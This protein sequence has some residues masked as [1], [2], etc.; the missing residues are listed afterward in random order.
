MK[1]LDKKIRNIMI[2]IFVVFVLLI[3][4]TIVRHKEILEEFKKDHDKSVL[5]TS[6]KI[7][8]YGLNIKIISILGNNFIDKDYLEY[9]T[10]EK[11]ITNDEETGMFDYNLIGEAPE[12]K[13]KLS[14]IYG[15]GRIDT[16][17]LKE[18]EIEM[19]FYLN[20][21]IKNAYELINNDADIRYV[22]FNDFVSI[23]P[24]RSTEEYE[25]YEKYF[26]KSIIRQ[27]KINHYLSKIIPSE[28]INKSKDTIIGKTQYFIEHEKYNN[29][30]MLIE[31]IEKDKKL[32]GMISVMLNKNY[33]RTLTQGKNEV[34]ITTTS[35]EIFTSNNKKYMDTSLS[36]FEILNRKMG[37]KEKRYNEL[38]EDKVNSYKNNYI[39]KTKIINTDA[40]VYS[41]LPSSKHIATLIKSSTIFIGSIVLLVYLIFAI[42]KV[43]NSSR[44]VMYIN[45]KLRDKQKELEL[46]AMIDPLTRL[47]NRR[48]VTKKYL[49]LH[50]GS[51]NNETFCILDIDYFKKINDKYGHDIGDIVLIELSSLITKHMK[52]TDIGAR[53]GGEEFLIISY[54]RTYDEAYELFEDLRKKIETTPIR[55]GIKE[56]NITASL[57]V[58]FEKDDSTFE[59]LVREVDEALYYGKNNGRNQVNRYE[60][61]KD[62]V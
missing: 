44:E 5:L 31:G 1:R 11:Y 34:F 60:E 4:G 3:G 20:R 29:S 55:I 27:S 50:D 57:G 58:S 28:N 39:L 48:G 12:L 15:K 42:K 47:R 54:D 59:K 9:S 56:I 33:F 25:D 10:M 17:K 32:I 46:L 36:M 8:L 23:Y 22:S 45:D 30:Y 53:W 19:V 26:N 6:L 51:K 2:Y 16:N 49:E 7:E 61:I 35:G 43:D 21:Y 14:N 38:K 62:M 24:F 41:V 52:E 13:E 37:I 18:K 40:Y